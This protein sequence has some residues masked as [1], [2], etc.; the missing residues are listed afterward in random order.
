VLNSYLHGFMQNIP[1]SGIPVP[2]LAKPILETVTNHSFFTGNTIESIG[3]ARLPVED[4]GR[5]AS[6]TAKMLSKMGLGAVTL[7]PAKI[8]NL[9][10]GY[11][12]EL[13]TFFTTLTDKVAYAAEGKTPPAVN[14]NKEPFLK[15]FL[16]DPNR[17]KAVG[18][19]YDILKNAD[20]VAQQFS[21]LK[22]Q[23]K[24][25]EIK[26]FASDK[27]KMLQVATAPALRRIGQN[28][29]A[30]RKQISLVQENQAMSPEERRDLINK[31]TQQYDR[32][33]ELGVR[34]AASYGLR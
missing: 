23:G 12:A 16:T 11:G 24:V 7:S 19:F 27:E 4:R 22:A 33:A 29:T 17:D 10:S 31:L 2:Q 3:D 14:L 32:V 13:G 6:E 8:D 28:M 21:Q 30:I 34:A 9:I 25:A 20:E 15:S 5:N 1:S 18:D 26:E